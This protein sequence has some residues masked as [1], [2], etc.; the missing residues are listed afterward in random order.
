MDTIYVFVVDGAEW[1]DIVI[2]LTKEEAIE[3]SIKYPTVRLELFIKSPKG[4]Y[5]PSYN[6]YL[7]GSYI[8]TRVRPALT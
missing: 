4:G 3:K 7:N 6:Y 5:R 1:E 8:E 2:F